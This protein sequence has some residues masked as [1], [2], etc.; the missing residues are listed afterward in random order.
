[1]AK[2][3]PDSS[4]RRWVIISEIRAERPSDEPEETAT[5]VKDP[6]AV[7]NEKA[8]PDEVFRI[9]SG[10]MNEPGW[11]TR[12]V[13]N[14][15]PITDFHEV[16]IHSPDAQR[17]ISLMNKD[18][19]LPIFQAYKAR[20]NAYQEQGSVMIFCN[21]GEGAGTSL[22]HPHSQLVLLPPQINLDALGREPTVN[23]V[24]EDKHFYA[25]CPEFSQWPYELWITPKKTETLFGDITDDELE[26]L[27][28]T[29][30]A[31]LTRLRAINNL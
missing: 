16:F 5:P 14:K 27:A 12:V 22:S 6:F 4:S 9:G 18:E 24:H 29:V 21:F 15:Y 2:Y 17:D 20:F 1:M 10:K 3:V 28:D 7:G 11:Q 26:I 30:R 8:S 31:M 25:Y 23:V 13:A 19:V